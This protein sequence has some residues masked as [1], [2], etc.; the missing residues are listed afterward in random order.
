[1]RFGSIGMSTQWVDAKG[2]LSNTLGVHLRH[3][4]DLRPH[5]LS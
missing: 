3:L 1:M 2:D 5:F 4:R